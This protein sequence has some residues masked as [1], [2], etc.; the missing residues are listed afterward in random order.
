MLA[1]GGNPFP[2]DLRDETV[3]ALVATHEAPSGA[4]PVDVVE[5]EVAAA[6]RFVE[7]DSERV[8]GLAWFSRSWLDRLN[9][10]E[11]RCGIIRVRGESV[12]PTLPDGCSILFDRNCRTP[13]DDRIYVVRAGDGL[14]GDLYT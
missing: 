6:V 14:I 11:T 4:R 10:N 5:F 8:P 7:I 13:P 9:L 12:E 2:P 1:A 3:A